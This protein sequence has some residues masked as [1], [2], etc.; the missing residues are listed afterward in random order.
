MP[1]RK[2]KNVFREINEIREKNGRERGERKKKKERANNRKVTKQ[3]KGTHKE[4]KKRTIQ[5]YKNSGERIASLMHTLHPM[6]SAYQL[7]VSD[8]PLLQT[9]QCTLGIIGQRELDP[10]GNGLLGASANVHSDL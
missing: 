6:F 4:R 1:C 2:K 10:C 3:K 5:T 9:P 7:D 8:V